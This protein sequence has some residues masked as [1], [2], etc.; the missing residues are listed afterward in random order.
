[1]EMINKKCYKITNENILGHEM[2]GLEI[3]VI[4]STDLARIGTKGI[5]VDE[6]QNTF[7]I[8]SLGKEKVI[9]KK[10][11]D[12]EFNLDGEKVIVIGKEIL[13]RSEDRTKEFRN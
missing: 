6:T 3:K 13:R 8:D 12:F 2:I 4:N 5:V 11:C 9:S 7:V 1:M 10:E